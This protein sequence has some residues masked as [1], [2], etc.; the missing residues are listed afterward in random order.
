MKNLII[1]KCNEL[2]KEKQTFGLLHFILY[3]L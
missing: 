2:L 1:V 3:N